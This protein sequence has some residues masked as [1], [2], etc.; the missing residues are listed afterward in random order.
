MT[1][2]VHSRVIFSIIEGGARRGSI[3]SLE[4][5]DVDFDA[6]KIY[7]RPEASKTAEAV[8]LDIS[9]SAPLLDTLEKWRDQCDNTRPNDLVFPS[10]KTGKRFTDIKKAWHSLT[11]AAF[12]WRLRI[13]AG[14]YPVVPVVRRSAFWSVRRSQALP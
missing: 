10:P 3:F 14:Y 6:K 9:K 13:Y 12:F 7:L 1:C 8:T 11:K 2:P 4:W 5:R